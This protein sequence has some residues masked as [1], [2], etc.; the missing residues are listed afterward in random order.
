V[1]AEP[2]AVFQHPEFLGQADLDMGVAA[3]PVSALVRNI[4]RAIED[5]VAQV[6]LGDRAEP[7]HRPGPRQIGGFLVCHVC[8]MDKAPA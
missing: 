4:G 2:L 3:D 6:P 5:A 1:V 7:C 8:R